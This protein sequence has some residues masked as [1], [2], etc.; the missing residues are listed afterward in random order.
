MFFMVDYMLIRSKRKTLSLSVSVEG[1]VVVRA[2]NRVS[3]R[4]IDG[5]VEKHF[6]WL[7][8]QL[9]LVEERKLRFPELSDV[10]VTELKKA[11]REY[12]PKRVEYYAALMGV[13]PSGIKITS[14]RKRF[15]SCSPNNSLCFSYLLMRYPPEEIDYVVVHELS[16]IIH[17]NHSKQFYKT[18]CGILSDYKA[19]AAILRQ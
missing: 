19:R 16:H 7:E 13:T 18:I 2:G 8:R 6:D 12:L 15:G 3:K 1:G 5:F 17:K 10:E 4:E 11:A 14:A 9:K